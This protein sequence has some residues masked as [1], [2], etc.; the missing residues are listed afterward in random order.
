[1]RGG[2]RW[3]GPRRP[4]A[5]HGPVSERGRCCATSLSP[6]VSR[7]DGEAAGRDGVLDREAVP[8]T[9]APA[10]HLE[11][12]ER[13]LQPRPPCD[14]R[15][16]STTRSNPDA[17]SSDGRNHPDT[18]PSRPP[19]TAPVT[20]PSAMT[21]QVDQVAEGAVA[22]RK[23]TTMA[24]GHPAAFAGTHRHGCRTAPRSATAC[25]TPSASARHQSEPGRGQRNDQRPGLLV[26]ATARQRGRSRRRRPTEP[27]DED[28]RQHVPSSG[29]AP[30]RTP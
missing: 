22:P 3:L 6:G 27:G 1:M 19:A 4:P 23:M 24:G 8:A 26:V 16:A 7:D 12:D 2:G 30:A 10:S 21:D 18:S 15:S 13:P 29:E 28:G 25:T 14:A 9:R 20:A 5:V 11:A 17:P